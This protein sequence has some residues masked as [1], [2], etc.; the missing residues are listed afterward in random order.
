MF[1]CLLHLIPSLSIAYPYLIKFHDFGQNSQEGMKHQM[2]GPTGDDFMDNS[3][4]KDFT[5]PLT[6]SRI[7]YLEATECN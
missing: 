4:V 3:I 5:R 2:R 1:S 7:N 6:Y